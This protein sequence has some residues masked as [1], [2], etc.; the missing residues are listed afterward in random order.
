[1]SLQ[2]TRKLLLLPVLF[3]ISFPALSAMVPSGVMLS[4]T[5]SLFRQNPG[6]PNTL[7]PGKG[8][9][10]SEQSIIQD[11]FA[12]LVYL[13]GNNQVQP[14]LAQSWE[15]KDGLTYV[16]HLRPGLVWSNGQPLTAEDF[17]YSWRRLLTKTNSDYATYLAQA[18]VVNATTVA[19][20][21]LPAESLGVKALD[22]NTLQVVLE[23]PNVNFIQMLTLPYLAPV[24]R[25]D[26]EEYGDKWTQ[27]GNIVSSGP[28]TLKSW[29]VNE[30]LVL[31]R[32]PR[33]YD[34]KDTIINQ[35]TY[36][37]IVQSQAAFDR[38]RAGEIDI[39]TI[40]IDMYRK[41]HTVDQYA[42]Q[43]KTTPMAGVYYYILN[44]T[45]P[46]FNDVRVRRA[47]SLALNKSVITDKVIAMGQKPA[48]LVAPNVIGGMDFTSP[49]W[50]QW[51]QEERN[52]EAKKL[53][54]E[55]GFSRNNPLIFKLLYNTNEAHKKIA[56]AASSMW[57]KTLG[58]NAKLTNEEWKT[59]LQDL[60]NRSF[61]VVRYAWTA[62]YNDA[63][64]FLYLF[65]T[66]NAMNNSGYSNPA[67]D[68]LLDAAARA[69]SLLKKNT[70][71]QQALTI[72]AQ[73]VPAIPIY[74]YVKVNAVKPWV[75][76]YKSNLLGY[77]YTRDMYVVAH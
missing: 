9:S 64:S 72:L 1:M 67:Y 46:P 60:D 48:Y 5:Q 70:Y 28:Y 40:P 47:L 57:E 2:I 27:P 11:L 77:T 36:L 55:A 13:D 23:R 32:N 52:S 63:S 43:I 17:V 24:N 12:G 49:P 39:S 26:V 38:Y 53:I 31:V 4:K 18:G 62:D 69:P 50:G 20:G 30:R 7:D 54:T 21:K 42:S 10:D 14:D 56:I 59:L 37:S 35:V 29:T 74:Q 71:Y 68:K 65:K 76:G 61:D 15:T 51:S 8:S 73:D 25:Q 16:F 6:E 66:G 44:V 3:I 45:R 41:L 22:D 75:G 58:V 19:K 33:Y 34:S